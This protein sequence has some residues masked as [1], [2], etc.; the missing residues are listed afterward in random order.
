M[1]QVAPQM[2][3]RDRACLR[4]S[5]EAPRDNFAGD[6]LDFEESSAHASVEPLRLSVAVRQRFTCAASF[7][8]TI[9]DNIRIVSRSS[10]VLLH[11]MHVIRMSQTRKA[12][13]ERKRKQQRTCKKRCHS[14]IPEDQ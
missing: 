5:L 14:A 13:R 2:S 7:G 10:D 4:A 1:A 3:E 12:C 6:I 11:G 8:V 9:K